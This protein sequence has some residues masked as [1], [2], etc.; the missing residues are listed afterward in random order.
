MTNPPKPI[1]RQK[2]SDEVRVRLLELIR[3]QSLEPGDTIPSE[4]ALM[5]QFGV[6]RPVVREAMQALQGMGLIEINHGERPRIAQPSFNNMLGQLGESIRHTLANSDTTL[7]NLKE[8]RAVFEAQMA[9]MAAQ[10]ATPRDVARLRNILDAQ[11]QSREDPAAFL[12]HD[13]AFHA[14]I[15][16]MSGNPIF[17]ALSRSL[18]GW[19]AEFH[20][21]LV[22]APNLEQLTLDEHEGILQAIESGAAKNAAARMADHLNRANDLYQKENLKR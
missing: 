3:E 9:R 13:A 14:H 16:E 4:R 17:A 22:R 1:R 2:R 6:G 7:D 19:L 21:G 10:R 15:A 11:A 18:F 12:E 20:S 8:A 5:A